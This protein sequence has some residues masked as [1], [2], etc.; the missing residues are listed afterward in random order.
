MA[1][2]SERLRDPS[3]S[4]IYR[5]ARWDTVADA[6]RG[7]QL[8]LAR[9]FL[10]GVKDRQSLLKRMAEALALPEGSGGDWDAL[11]DCLAELEGGGDQAGDV[12]SPKAWMSLEPRRP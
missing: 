1:S 2:L 12:E 11:Q 6:A 10:N 8:N 7:S 4:G 9:I 3:R 5:A